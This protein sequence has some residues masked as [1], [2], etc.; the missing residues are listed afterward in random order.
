[1]RKMLLVAAV[2]TGGL[3]SAQS[4]SLMTSKTPLTV[5]EK[6]SALS[7]EWY[8]WMAGQQTEDPLNSS[9]MFKLDTFLTIKRSF[10]TTSSLTLEPR[11]THDTG[12][13][14]S[15]EQGSDTTTDW[16]VRKAEFDSSPSKYFSFSAGALNQRDRFSRLMWGDRAIPSLELDL[17]TRQNKG[18]SVGAKALSGVVSSTQLAAETGPRGETPQFQ[19]LRLSV[20]YKGPVLQSNTQI[21]TYRF[22]ALSESLAKNSAIRGNSVDQSGETNQSEF[23]SNFAGYFIDQAWTTTLKH[24]KLGLSLNGVKNQEAKDEKNTAY[25]T[26]TL[27]QALGV[28]LEPQFKFRFYR[29][30]SDAAV[31]SL[32]SS[33][34]NTNRQGYRAELNFTFEDYNAGFYG[35]LSDS[36]IENP[37]QRRENFFGLQLETQYELL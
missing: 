19:S 25:M 7:L 20:N 18:W 10:G 2:L 12:F 8:S 1:M 14:Q 13:I 15:E 26:E 33:T 30:E 9:Q 22:T 28:S 27:I 6:K 21:G 3:A 36:L 34:L 35:G 4:S 16:A 5:P 29:V 32:L 23:E 11:L 37:N 31:A 17:H 24:L